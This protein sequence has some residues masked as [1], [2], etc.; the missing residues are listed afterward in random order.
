MC[1]VT[2]RRSTDTSRTGDE[3]SQYDCWYRPRMLLRVYT[4]IVATITVAITESHLRVS[5]DVVRQQCRGG[6]SGRKEDYTTISADSGQWWARLLSRRTF[7][8]DWR[9][10]SSLPTRTRLRR[11]ARQPPSR[12]H[13]HVLDLYTRTNISPVR[14]LPDSR[15]WESCRMGF[16]GD[17]PFPPDLSF[18]R[19]SIL[20]S[21]TLVGCQDLDVKSRPNLFTRVH[22]VGQHVGLHVRDS[23]PTGTNFPSTAKSSETEQV[24]RASR[25]GEGIGRGLRARLHGDNITIA[26]ANR[27]ALLP[28]TPLW[29]GKRISIT[30]MLGSYCEEL[31]VAQLSYLIERSPPTKANRVRIPAGVTMYVGNVADGV[32]GRRVFSGISRYP[33]PCIPAMPFPPRFTLIGSQA[34]KSHILPI[35]PHSSANILLPPKANQVSVRDPVTG[36]VLDDAVDR[37]VFSGIFHFPQHFHSGAASS[38]PQSPSSALEPSLALKSQTARYNGFRVGRP[39]WLQPGSVMCQADTESKGEFPLKVYCDGLPLQISARFLDYSLSDLHT[40][41][42]CREQ[43]ARKAMKSS[44]HRL[45]CSP[46]TK[47]NWV[48]SPAGQLFHVGLVP[49]DATSRQGFLGDPQFPP[50]LHFGA[51]SHSPQS[52]TSARKTSIFKSRPNPFTYRPTLEAFRQAKRLVTHCPVVHL[53]R[54]QTELEA[55]DKSRRVPAAS[56]R[57]LQRI[58]REGGGPG[59]GKG[60]LLFGSVRSVRWMTA[61]PSSEVAVSYL[62]PPTPHTILHCREGTVT[63]KRLTNDGSFCFSACSAHSN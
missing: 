47:A 31:A 33:H 23:T 36:I 44:E 61:V 14:P 15:M 40:A 32:T 42:R 37:R 18:R 41:L 35:L 17:L 27:S 21:I 58:S 9:Y 60:D 53:T 12:E 63:P 4:V 57:N 20:T 5:S 16:P 39:T 52:P 51:A 50:P 54:Q 62:W 38:S 46:P 55:T 48:Q 8:T 30:Q 34:L 45:D 10:T 1:Y 59:N 2:R 22:A 3:C 13:H 29:P 24:A 56:R 25:T 19:C 11:V 28:C 26:T 7:H 43:E 49:D 6:D